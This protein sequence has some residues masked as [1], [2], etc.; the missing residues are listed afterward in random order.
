MSQNNPKDNHFSDLQEALLRLSQQKS[1][2]QEEEERLWEE[3]MGKRRYH[4]QKRFPRPVPLITLSY[5]GQQHIISTNG[6]LT[7]FS[8]YKKVGKSGLFSA[9][10]ATCLGPFKEVEREFNGFRIKRNLNQWALIYIDT[11]QSDYDFYHFN[12]HKVKSRLLQQVLPDWYH[13]INLRP[14]A[15]NQRMKM[16][17]MIITRLLSKH[18]GIHA[19]FIDGIADFCHSVNNEQEANALVSFFEQMAIKAD[20]PLIATMHLNP[21]TI[22]MRGHLGSQLERKAESIFLMT[23]DKNKEITYI[24]E[25]ALRNAGGKDFPLIELA[26]DPQKGCHLIKGLIPKKQPK[27]QSKSLRANQWTKNEHQELLDTIFQSKKELS[28]TQLH[29][30]IQ[31]TYKVSDKPARQIKKHLLDQGWIVTNGAAPRSS[32]LRF[33]RPKRPTQEE[34]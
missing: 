31:S 15:P 2:E 14:Y 19:I 34:E 32:H 18:Q 22:K 12:Q 13:A 11:E 1:K 8:G 17:E 30:A 29:E 27:Q 5:N 21:G 28:Y 6:N 24:T 23:K 16:T 4:C 9:L 10:L 25:E 20:C 3:I 7:I 33:L 26:F